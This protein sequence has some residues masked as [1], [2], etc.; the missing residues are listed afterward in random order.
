LGKPVNTVYVA[1]SRIHRTLAD[2]V[3]RRLTRIG[4]C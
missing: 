4:E 2:C 1:L 3:T